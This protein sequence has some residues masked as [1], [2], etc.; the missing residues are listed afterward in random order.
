MILVL[1]AGFGD[2]HNTAASSTAEALR[3][4]SPGETIEVLDL[5]SAVQPRVASAL[6]NLYQQ[7]I[8]HFPSGWRLVYRLLEKSDVEPQDAAWLAPMVRGLKKLIETLQPRIIVST[9][10][11]HATLLDV[12]RKQGPVPPLVTIITDSITVHR[13]WLTQPSELYCVADDETRHVVEM[14][15][16]PPESIR[17]TGFPV[18]LRFTEPL[19]ASVRPVGV[20]RILYLPS[21]TARRVGATLRALRPLL[22]AGVRL[23]IPVGK[24]GSRLYHVLRKF[25]D[26]LQ[27]LSSVEIIGWTD[28]IPELLRTHDVVI[29]KAGGAILHEILAAQVPAVIDYVVPGQEEGNAEL[30]VSNHCAIRT[31]T[32]AE[33]GEA[34]R[35]ILADGGRLAREMRSHMAPISVPDAA[36][37][38]AREILALAN[39]QP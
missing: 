35:R 29:C 23:T 3:R 11:V 14:E 16:I 26:T 32:A 25:T 15:G 17:I 24:H 4:L 8:T 12:L 9:Y 5:I 38:A 20:Q 36:L 37:R 34:A 2:G 10:P 13:I 7:A 21:T 39:L 6:K 22:E 30:L 27:D 33:T 28:R 1:T 18:S 31:E 19:P